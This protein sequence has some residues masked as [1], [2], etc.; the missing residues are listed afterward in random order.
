ML[1]LVKH[2]FA[3]CPRGKDHYSSWA[4]IHKAYGSSL[5]NILAV[6]DLTH[7]ISPSSAE[8]ERGFSKLRNIK[9]RLRSRLSQSVLNDIMCVKMEGKSISEFDPSKA[10]YSWSTS[11]ERTR[12]VDIPVPLMPDTSSAQDQNDMI[13]IDD[14][15][16]EGDC[17][18]KS[19]SDYE[20]DEESLSDEMDDF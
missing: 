17:C 8:A 11:S 1:F 14:Q 10:I 16:V 18:A 13:I 5:Q 12:R 9:T 6:V 2:I 15:E 19:N 3:F 4:A 7:S 20:S